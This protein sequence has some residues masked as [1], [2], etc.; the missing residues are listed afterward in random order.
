MEYISVEEAAQKWGLSIR[1]VQ[2]HC[3]KDLK[4]RLFMAREGRG[5]VSKITNEGIILR[6]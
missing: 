4:V 1:S 5:I 2:L 3:Q 6:C